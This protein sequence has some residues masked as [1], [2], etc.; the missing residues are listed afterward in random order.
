MLRKC[1]LYITRTRGWRTKLK[2]TKSYELI[3]RG[4]FWE[5][6]L[7]RNYGHYLKIEP[8]LVFTD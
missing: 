2:D 8:N 1:H 4:R 7:F 5:S 6:F 3:W